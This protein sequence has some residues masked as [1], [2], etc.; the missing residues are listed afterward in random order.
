MLHK[1]N[2]DSLEIQQ[3]SKRAKSYREALNLAPDARYLERDLISIFLHKIAKPQKND[4]VGD[5]MA[6]D[7]YVAAKLA[8]DFKVIAFE[9]CAE[10]K[11]NSFNYENIKVY[12]TKDLKSLA[13]KC[14]KLVNYVISLAGFH[15]IVHTKENSIVDLSTSRQRQIE[16]INVLFSKN[17]KV[18]GMLLGDV[19][20]G[21]NKIFCNGEFKLVTLPE[22]M[23]FNSGSTLID[24]QR[25]LE[26]MFNNKLPNP[27][28]W[29]REYVNHL[30]PYGHHD[31]F[32]GPDFVQK[33]RDYGY[34]CSQCFVL[35]PWIF[36][37]KR[38]LKEFVQRKFF[39]FVKSKKKWIDF[40]LIEK[41]IRKI[42]QI[43]KFKNGYALGW[44]LNFLWITKW[45]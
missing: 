21:Y 17:S 38:I 30:N 14:A 12:T 42:L 4:I 13:E 44:A 6:G 34:H 19:A 23:R 45:N 1:M 33:L 8:E 27:A 7:G 35:V 24:Q 28:Q 22:N 20:V 11:N 32:I 29:F 43:N 36:Q 18:R 3:F 26:Y 10:M 9:N 5:F 25:G 39:L 16:I 37:N 40:E 2:N 15:H 31:C 41:D